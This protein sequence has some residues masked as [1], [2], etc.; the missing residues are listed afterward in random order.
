MVW[1]THAMARCKGGPVPQRLTAASATGQ[2]R[3]AGPFVK[4]YETPNT[5][6][7]IIIT[8][9]HA[10]THGKTTDAD[11]R[12]GKYAV[13]LAA[14]LARTAKTHAVVLIVAGRGV[15]RTERDRQGQPDSTQTHD[16]N[17]WAPGEMRDYAFG[18]ELLAAFHCA[19]SGSLLIDVHSANMSW[20]PDGLKEKEKGRPVVMA[21]RSVGDRPFQAA[22]QA[23]FAHTSADAWLDNNREVVAST[24][25]SHA[26]ERRIQAVAL[27]FNADTLVTRDVDR[28]VKAVLAYVASRYQCN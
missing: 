3:I 2:S 19:T 5:K 25:V 7:V 21:L 16:H 11:P 4:H 18:T 12:S 23:E 17:R 8:A 26:H 10:N 24:I 28:V 15:S 20:A 22:M 1:Y 9:P 6:P 13:H 14:A 27:E